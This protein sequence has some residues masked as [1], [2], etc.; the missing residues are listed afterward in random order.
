MTRRLE[1]SI[2]P[3]PGLVNKWGVHNRHS[4]KSNPLKRKPLQK[5]INSYQQLPTVKKNFQS[6]PT[7][8]FRLKQ[9]L[10]VTL[11]TSILNTSI[12]IDDTF[13]SIILFDGE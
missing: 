6:L 2:L 13:N 4:P 1:D 12:L 3:Q 10:T 7:V 5:V 11:H 8:T 9:L